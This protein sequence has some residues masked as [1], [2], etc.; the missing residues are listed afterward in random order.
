MAQ[1]NSKR[2]KL[3]ARKQW[4]V[5]DMEIENI[6]RTSYGK[7]ETRKLLSYLFKV[8]NRSERNLTKMTNMVEEDAMQF[9]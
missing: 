4:K 3:S 9:T 5:T 8:Y 6:E 2:I 1:V 7:R